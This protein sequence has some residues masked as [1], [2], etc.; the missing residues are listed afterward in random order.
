MEPLTFIFGAALAIFFFLYL[1]QLSKKSDLKLESTRLQNWNSA[2]EVKDKKLS[3][4]EAELNANLADKKRQ[5]ESLTTQIVYSIE[6]DEVGLNTLHY[7]FDDSKQYKQHIDIIYDKQKEL[8]KYKRACV[9]NTPWHINGNKAEGTKVTKQITKL[10]LR[11][12]NGECESIIAKVKYG[13]VYKFEGLIEKSFDDINKL[14]EGFTCYLTY[15]YRDLKIQEL[16]LVYEYNEKLYNEKEEQ[17]SLREQMRE[18]EKA[19]KEID[20]AVEAAAEEEERYRLALEKVKYELAASFAKGALAS[21]D[22]Q[23]KLQSQVSDLEKKLEAALIKNQRTIA[24]A[25]LTKRGH[26]YVIS[27]VGSFGED[28]FKIGMTRRLDP[29][30][31]VDELGGASVPFRFYVHAFIA[32]DDAPKLENDLHKMFEDKR[33]N[34][35]NRRKEFFKA[36]FNEIETAVKLHNGEIHLT[37]MAEAKEELRRSQLTIDKHYVTSVLPD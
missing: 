9:C 2:L 37:K 22:K 23:D 27:N 5:L 13:N 26:V 14:G 19:R 30:E 1:N 11:A 28:V 7:N 35:A 31:R 3:S 15:E 17:K 29:Q 21:K 36:S 12:F 16:H 8:I 6:F 32:S 18:E 33:V 4:A 34:K 20:R 25:Q 10:M 24:Q